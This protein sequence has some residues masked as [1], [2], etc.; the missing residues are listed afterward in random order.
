MSTFLGFEPHL[1]ARSRI[2]LRIK[3]KGR[4]RIRIK[5]TS[6]IRIRIR[7][8]I[9]VTRGSGSGSASKVTRRIRIIVM[10]IRNTAT[11]VDRVSTDYKRRV[12]YRYF[13]YL[14]DIQMFEMFAFHGTKTCHIHR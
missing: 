9:K 7:V 14:G 13:T 1:E 5:V 8:R 10:R 6:G 3:V 11:L 4:I 12:P 2:R